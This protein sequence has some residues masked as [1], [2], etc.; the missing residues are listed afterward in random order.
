M[1]AVK[2]AFMSR[3]AEAVPFWSVIPVGTVTSGRLI[4]RDPTRSLVLDVVHVAIYR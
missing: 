3:Y 2:S 4:D 1:M